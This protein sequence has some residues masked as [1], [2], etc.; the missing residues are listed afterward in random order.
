MNHTMTQSE[1]SV[2]VSAIETLIP[3]HLLNSSYVVF[4]WDK[5]PE[6]LRNLFNHNGGDEDWLVIVKKYNKEFQHFWIEATDSCR[7]P[8][9]Y[10]LG[11]IEVFVGCHA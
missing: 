8:N 6:V 4:P 1:I 3:R 10:D 2:A 9:Y 5:A 11:E 7:D